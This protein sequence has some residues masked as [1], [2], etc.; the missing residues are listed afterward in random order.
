MAPQLP[1]LNLVVAPGQRRATLDIARE[2][3]RHG[4]A[5][6]SVSSQYSNMAQTGDQ[7]AL[8]IAGRPRP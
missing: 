1:A 7:P 6:I 8:H 3:E 5:G 4:F 2:I